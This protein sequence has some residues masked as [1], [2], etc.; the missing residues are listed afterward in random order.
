MLTCLEAISNL[1]QIRKVVYQ[2]AKA[3][4]HISAQGLR[5]HV[6]KE[7]GN[8]I[9]DGTRCIKSI[10]LLLVACNLLYICRSRFDRMFFNKASALLLANT[11]LLH[12]FR[13]IP[14]NSQTP[15]LSDKPIFT[16]E[17]VS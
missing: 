6:E 5:L 8:D 14:S 10:I 16:W 17:N 11:D 13:Q 4:Y 15:F 1:I 7:Q 9:F 2:F 12:P 3:H